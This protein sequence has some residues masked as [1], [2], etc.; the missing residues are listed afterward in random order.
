MTSFLWATPAA[1]DEPHRPTRPEQV[2]ALQQSFDADGWNTS[3]PALVGYRLTKSVGGRIQLLSGSH[4]HAAASLAQIA[5]PIVV[6]PRDAVDEAWGDLDKW[7]EIMRS[8]GDD[9]T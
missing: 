5:V 4:R 1:C 6:W 2:D 8:G 7:K 9:Q 3:L